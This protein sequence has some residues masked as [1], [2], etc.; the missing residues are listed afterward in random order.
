MGHDWRVAD[1]TYEVE[2]V[3]EDDGPDAALRDRLATVAAFRLGRLDVREGHYPSV[4]E[5]FDMLDNFDG[6]F[7]WER[8]DEQ[9]ADDPP[10]ASI[11][12]CSP[13]T[14]SSRP[15]G[16]HVRVTVRVPF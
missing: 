8:T 12:R 10:T 9:L 7:L 14:R 13:S 11:S 3:E 6:P 16:A 5:S 1:R 4:G 2:V 15:A